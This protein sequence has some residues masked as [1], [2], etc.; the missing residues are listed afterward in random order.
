MPEFLTLRMKSILL[1]SVSIWF[2][3]SFLYFSEKIQFLIDANSQDLQKAEF[4]TLCTN[5]IWYEVNACVFFFNFYRAHVIAIG[6]KFVRPSVT[7]WYCVETAQPIIK[8]S[9]LP[10]SSFLRTKLFPG[11]PMRTPPTGALNAR[12]RK[13]LQ[14]QTNIS[15]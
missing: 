5:S 10:D 15:L 4:Q 14:F 8:L 9:S 6:W 3:F 13:K 1:E 12:G 2:F 7:R 11:I